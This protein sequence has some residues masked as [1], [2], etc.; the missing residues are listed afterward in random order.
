MDRS[1][2]TGIALI[3]AILIGYS[4]LT[5]PSRE[6]MAEQKRI[7][8]SISMVNYQEAAALAAANAIDT[9]ASQNTPS[10]TVAN[11]PVQN[12]VDY[13]VFSSGLEGENAF[14]TIENENLILKISK[15]GGKPFSV[16]LKNYRDHDSLP[17]YL[18][19][20]EEN[21]FGLEFFSDGKSIKTNDLFFDL[22]E[23]AEN[24]VVSTSPKSLVM[25]LNVD[26][27]GAF[28]EYKYTVNPDSYLLDF[29]LKMKG[30]DAYRTDNVQL[31]WEVFSPQHEKGRQNE[32]SYT[33]LYYRFLEGDIEKFK[34]RSKQD[35]QEITE[36]TKIQWLGYKQQFF[37]SVILAEDKAFEGGYMSSELQ[38]ENSKYIRHFNSEL[39][40][41]YDRTSNFEMPVKFYFGPNH[42]QTL[43]KIGFKL[44]EL[45]TIG[46]SIIRVLNAYIIIPIFNWLNNFIGNYGIIILLLTLIIKTALFPLT[47]KSYLSQAKMRALKPE[48]DEINS[49]IPKEKSVERQQATM[50]LYRKVGVNPMGGCLPMLLQMPILYAM[51][52]FFPLSI[53]L[54]QES[55]LWA[56]DLSTY[57]SILN[58]PFTIPMYGDHVSLFTLLMTVST[59][60]SMKLNSNPTGMDSQMPG[61]KGMMYI[62]P[63]MFMLILNNFSS[64][65][66]YY[67]FLANM[68]TLGQNYIFKLF[69]D[70]EQLRKK[71]HAKKAKAK[72]KSNF[73]KRIEEAAKQRGYN[74]PKR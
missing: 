42:F 50:A 24:I 16:E 55:F 27:F 46:G 36:T 3:I 39:N 23:G 47:Y 44:D 6:E 58:L 67:Y 5:K 22:E 70:E 2:I 52:R 59:M 41:P 38:D 61:M 57:D 68:I 49:K 66:T 43:K 69:I 30:M 71:L 26:S 63:V 56:H 54:R 29:D 8:D 7:A 4:L 28:I 32:S 9:P 51:F 20:G 15:K 13:G 37:S 17:L 33:N 25:R 53:E 35:I 12:N 64:G 72:P 19:Q 74:L 34:L 31:R 21:Q 40:V 14:Y 18:F 65:L 11:T 48:I 62:M 10:Q 73:Q 45:V 60:L 1:S